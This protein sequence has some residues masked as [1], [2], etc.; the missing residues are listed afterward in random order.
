MYV[1]RCLE[2]KEFIMNEEELDSIPEIPMIC[3]ECGEDLVKENLVSGDKPIL[4]VKCT[5]CSYSRF[6]EVCEFEEI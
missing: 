5:S 2:L 1:F 6:Y 4:L 3:K